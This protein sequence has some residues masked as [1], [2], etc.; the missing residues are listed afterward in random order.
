MAEASTFWG[1]FTTAGAASGEQPWAAHQDSI[2]N[3]RQFTVSPAQRRGSAIH[4]DFKL[5]FTCVLAN[6]SISS[7]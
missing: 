3:A 5:I 7:T 4:T 1:L 6:A 2:D